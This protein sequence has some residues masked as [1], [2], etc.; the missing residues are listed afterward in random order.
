MAL[1]G[2][3][4]LGMATFPG[5]HS[6]RDAR[7]GSEIDIK[8][9]PSRPVSE[10]VAWALVAASL[11]LMVSALWQH[12]AAA[13]VVAI[14]STTAQGKDVVGDIGAASITLVW[15]S[16]ALVMIAVQGTIVMIL[17]IRLLDWLTDV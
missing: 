1:T 6:E 9:F 7:T 8:P 14:V 5:W 13:S 12:V 2:L 10:A 3:G 4:F 15:L 16:F 11:L 17:S